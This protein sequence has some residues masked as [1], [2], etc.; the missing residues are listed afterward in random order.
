MPKELKKIIATAIVTSGIVGGGFYASDTLNCDYT[1]RYQEEEICIDQ[2]IKDAI[3]S[4]LK[5]NAGFG[6][7]QFSGE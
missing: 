2:E 7:V 4:G 3:G 5:P 6:G 1:I